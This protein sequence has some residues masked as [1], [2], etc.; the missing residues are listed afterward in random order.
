MIVL[1]ILAA[2]VGIGLTVILIKAGATLWALL[3]LDAEVRREAD[4]GLVQPYPTAVANAAK[5][6]VRAQEAGRP[7]NTE[8]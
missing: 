4:E 8:G 3:S 6:Y 5:S 7:P 1:Q 2:L